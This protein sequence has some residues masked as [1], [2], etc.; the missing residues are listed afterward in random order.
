MCPIFPAPAGVLY[1]SGRKKDGAGVISTTILG[2]NFLAMSAGRD[3][4][5]GVDVEG[6]KLGVCKGELV[7]GAAAGLQLESITVSTARTRTK[8]M[9]ANSV[10][11]DI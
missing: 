2:V 9:R 5:A 4:W 8:R 7:D 1:G 3:V 11:N 10:W 6:D